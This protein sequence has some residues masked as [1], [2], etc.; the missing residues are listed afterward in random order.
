[1]IT[2]F[3]STFWAML[4]EMAPYLLLGF[5][6][7][8]ILHAFIPGSFYNRHLSRPGFG[9]VVKSALMG[10][11]LPLCSCGVI[12][13]AMALRREGASKGATVSFLI[14][15]PQTGVDSIAATY[16]MLG[17][18]FAIVR[19]IAAL[20]TAV[21]GGMMANERAD[22]AV[23]ASSGAAMTGETERKSFGQRCKEALHYGF[24]DMLQDLGRWLLLGLVIATVITMAVPDDFFARF[25]SAPLLGMLLVLVISVPMYLCATGSIPIAL[26]L[27]MKGLSPGAALVLLMAGPAT[28][29]A[30]I[31]M[32]YKVLGR[33]T[34][35][36]YVGSIIAGAIAFGLAIDYLMPASWFAIS[37]LA[38]SGHS[39][40]C[41]ADVPSAPWFE[42]V[43]GIVLCLLLAVGLFTRHH[44]HDNEPS[45]VETIKNQTMM[46]FKISG[47]MCN[48]CR[49][50]VEKAIAGLPGVDSVTVDLQNG[51][52]TVTGTVEAS[53]V[54]AAVEALGYDCSES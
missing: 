52:A 6:F 9:S 31:L 10:V 18:P 42:A 12:P 24:G 32:V 45:S 2:E 7:A 23:H 40:H 37:P 13:T 30:S 20:V 21:F 27:V 5:L 41:A 46:T 1:M 49:T 50:N 4:C 44:H 39:A 11:P 53:A 17:L 22:S 48:H 51:S 19:P 15:T 38:G 54:K 14:A 33:R 34:T 8:G 26:A 29:A 36:I 47:M 28:N 16:S 3:L 25:A 35:A 43:S